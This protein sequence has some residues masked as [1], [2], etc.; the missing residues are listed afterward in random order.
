MTRNCSRRRTQFQTTCRQNDNKSYQGHCSREV[1]VPQYVSENICG[2]SGTW[3]V[4]DRSAGTALMGCVLVIASETTVRKRLRTMRPIHNRNLMLTR[5]L[6]ET[7]VGHKSPIDARTYGDLYRPD[8]SFL[9]PSCRNKRKI[10][11]KKQCRPR[12]MLS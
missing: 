3:L 11:Y 10:F 1:Q 6:I 7:S 5:H 2:K 8:L 9:T 4:F 12:M